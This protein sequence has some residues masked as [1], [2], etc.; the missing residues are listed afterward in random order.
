MCGT[1]EFIEEDGMGDVETYVVR[2]DE[3]PVLVKW[4]LGEGG[5]EK[6]QQY[7]YPHL[8]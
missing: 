6:E 5:S 3:D 7:T 2:K 4:R 8:F 1:S